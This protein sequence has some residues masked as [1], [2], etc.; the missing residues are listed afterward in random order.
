[1]SNIYE[2]DL[3]R[4]PANFSA[5]S[6]LSFIERS[7]RVYPDLPAIVHGSGQAT[8]RRTWSETY[9]RCRQLASALAGRGVGKGD[10][11]AVLLPNTPP[12]VEAH[13]GV[14]MTGAVLNTI[15]RRLDPHTVAY[16]LD[17]GEASVLLVDAEFA[18]VARR[19]LEMRQ[20]DKPITIIDVH[21]PFYAGPV[22]SLS[23]V[24]YETFIAGGD[25]EYEWS[26][27]SDEWD[28]IALNYTSGT[29]GNPK[30][31]VYH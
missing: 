15:N 22:E 24:E 3:P 21:D 5:L 31:V 11:V 13:F 28:A 10:T 4:T 26:L 2:Q 6:P 16:I 20:S 8:I 18:S 1:M 12:M 19:A 29:T 9:R 7:A 25:P 14:P 30:G 17:H 23:D 27:P